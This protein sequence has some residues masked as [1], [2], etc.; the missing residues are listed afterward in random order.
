MA[1]Q[2]K[3]IVSSD[4]RATCSAF[5]LSRNHQAGKSHRDRVYMV[6]S[7]EGARLTIGG[8]NQIT[9]II[10]LLSDKLAVYTNA[11]S[12]ETHR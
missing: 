7:V 1:E 8:I 3:V 6:I 10:I 9:I 2:L 5:T 11:L 4:L 12:E